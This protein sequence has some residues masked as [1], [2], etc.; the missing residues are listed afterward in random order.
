MRKSLSVKLAKI[1]IFTALISIASPLSIPMGGGVSLSLTTFVIFIASALL[2]PF[3]ALVSVAIYLLLGV[4]GVPIFQNFTGGFYA[5]VG[6]TGGY[7]VG[8]LPATLISGLIIRK[9]KTFPRYILAFSVATL[10]IYA[11]GFLWF[12]YVTMGE[13]SLGALIPSVLIFLPFDIVKI[14]IASLISNKLRLKL[15]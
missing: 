2:P 1:A 8:Y 9:R 3:E 10:I 6:A 7:L 12:S 15:K 4:I 13:I 5:I 11:L 14:V